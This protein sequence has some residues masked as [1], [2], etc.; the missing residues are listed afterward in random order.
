MP[1]FSQLGGMVVDGG[2]EEGLFKLDVVSSAVEGLLRLLSVTMGSA[3][4]SVE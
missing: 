2:V 1:V 4:F 3:G